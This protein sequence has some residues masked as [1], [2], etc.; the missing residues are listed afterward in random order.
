[1][2]KILV[3]KIKETSPKR[4]NSDIKLKAGY[5]EMELFK[6]FKESFC[7]EVK[8]DLLAT[9]EII[10]A[11][12]FSAERGNYIRLTLIFESSLHG[13][14]FM[15]NLSKLEHSL[16]E[17]V[18]LLPGCQSNDLSHLFVEVEVDE[19]LECLENMEESKFET[20]SLASVLFET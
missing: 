1:M 5:C 3:I 17:D 18:K 6:A 10:N 15:K 4:D 13:K 14:E 7:S 12:I 19:D 8:K 11:F 20:G 9:L 16:M 2:V